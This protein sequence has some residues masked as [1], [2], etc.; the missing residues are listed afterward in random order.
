MCGVIGCVGTKDAQEVLLAGLRRLE[1]RG[2]DSAGMV[3]QNE[4][5]LHGTKSA[6]NIS[7]LAARL[8]AKPLRGFAGI[9]HTRWATHGEPTDR[10][11]HPHFSCDRSLAIVHNG[12]VENYLALKKKLAAK[13]HRFL[14][15]TDTEI[16]A[17]LVEQYYKGDPVE[18]VRR[19]VRELEGSFAIVAVFKDHPNVLVSARLNSPLIVG[20]NGRQQFVASDI[21]ALLPYTRR[22]A[23]LSEAEIVVLE[24]KGVT[25]MDFD[26]RAR[27]LDSVQVEW[28]AS[29]AE[30]QG[31]PHYMLKEIMEEPEVAE[32]GLTGRIDPAGGA[33]LLDKTEVPTRD[34]RSIN[35]ILISGCGT[36]WHAGLY[37][38][39]VIEELAG[40]PVQAELASELRYGSTPLDRNTLM[41][42]ISQ[43]GETADTLASV[44]LA[45]EKGVRCLA[46]T[47]IR[48]ST[49][50]R[51]ADWVLPMRAG[52]E[53]GVAATKTYLAQLISVLLFALHAGQVR[54]TLAPARRKV[55]VR[56]LHRVPKQIQS[57]L[58]DTKEIRAVAEKYSRKHDFMY[59]GRTV[60]LATAYEGA[61]KMKEISYLHAEGYGAGEMKH[62]PLALVDENLVTV[63]LAVPGKVYHKML[64]NIQEVRA[65]K[66]KVIAVA[67]RDDA[68]IRSL[69]DHVFAVPRTEELLSPVLNG[70]PLQLLAY[71]TAVALGR[72]VD[73]P[74]NLAKSVTVE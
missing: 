8:R 10:N 43:S 56:A 68:G 34:L 16:I 61:L 49:L 46:I 74:R 57:I 31:Y 20:L 58:S 53:I 19:C 45:R 4:K 17:H 73:Q 2:Y 7:V 60:N 30:K 41:I 48:G 59:I 14:S 42:A 44:R 28:D 36:A 23:Y 72:D 13:G 62:G 32:V 63:A 24:P 3:I 47:N 55:L 11:A 21:S 64:S 39:Y 40:I 33:I 6:G 51:M 15:E 27:A 66:G 70:V 1:Y 65:R 18:A 22:V 69:V 35:R 9:G 25:V 5:G 12:I 29:T 54:K 52:L 38:K 71:Y 50:S 67:A 26:G 37:G